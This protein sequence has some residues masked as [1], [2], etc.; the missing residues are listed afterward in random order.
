MGLHSI[1]TLKK[2]GTKEAISFG[3]PLIVNGKP[4]IKSGDGGWGIAPRT[5]IAQ[6]YDGKI[7]FIVIDGRRIDSAGATLKDVQDIL[8]D[9]N[10]VNAV[11][12]DGG[13]S[14]AMFFNGKI[15]NQT[16]NPLGEREVPSVFMVVP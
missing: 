11:N 1:F 6:T 15:I 3:P 12:L 14:T 9:F 5:A 13:S 7:I 2:Y 8:L 10:A 16:A 4:S